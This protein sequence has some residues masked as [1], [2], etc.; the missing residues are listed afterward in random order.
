MLMVDVGD[1]AADD[2]HDGQ[3]FVKGGRY[4]LLDWGDAACPTRSS[5]SR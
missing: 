1:E 2:L 5:R 3:V 4:L